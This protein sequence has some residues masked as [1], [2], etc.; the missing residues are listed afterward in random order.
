M[1]KITFLI[2]SLALIIVP[3]AVF[4]SDSPKLDELGETL[5]GVAIT[6]GTYI[7]VIGWVIA[8][9]LFLLAQGDPQKFT[10]A[11]LALIAAVIGTVAIALAIGGDVI[12]SIR[13]MLGVGGSGGGG[14]G[15]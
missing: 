4:A 9:I 5:R 15:N 6:V 1:K 2:L 14:S 3:L 12:E 8:G 11:K 13:N 7:V 10:K